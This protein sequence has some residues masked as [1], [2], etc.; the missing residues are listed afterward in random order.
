[1]RQRFV[2]GCRMNAPP[3]APPRGGEVLVAGR[4]REPGAAKLCLARS[5][6]RTDEFV[7]VKSSL[8]PAAPALDPAQFTHTKFK[9]GKNRVSVLRLTPSSHTALQ[10]S[11]PFRNTF[12]RFIWSDQIDLSGFHTNIQPT[13]SP[14]DNGPSYKVNVPRI[15]GPMKSFA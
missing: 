1:M 11:C 8:C 5:R 13:A 6:Q 14:S 3:L 12:L 10:Q 7:R 2:S 15:V 4:A 9:R